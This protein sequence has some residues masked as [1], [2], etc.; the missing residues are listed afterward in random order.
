MHHISVRSSFYSN[1]LAK[2]RSSGLPA[3]ATHVSKSFA[4]GLVLTILICC[5]RRPRQIN[6]HSVRFQF[7]CFCSLTPGRDSAA[8]EDCDFSPCATVESWRASFLT[9]A[10]FTSSPDCR[11]LNSSELSI[12]SHRPS[13]FLFLDCRLTVSFYA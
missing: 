5:D 2:S 8:C 13:R 1:T 10:A 9:G 3:Q 7:P 11:G 4:P 12:E 6:R